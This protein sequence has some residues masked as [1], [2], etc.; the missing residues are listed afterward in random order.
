MSGDP[1][2]IFTFDDGPNPK[3]TPFILDALKAHHIHAVFFMIVVDRGP[4]PRRRRR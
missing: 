1:E 3:T 2:L 4:R